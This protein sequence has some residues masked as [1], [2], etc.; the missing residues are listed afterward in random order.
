MI[1]IEAI[2]LI[3][4]DNVVRSYESNTCDR[5]FMR[6][7]RGQSNWGTGSLQSISNRTR[8][9]RNNIHGNRKSFVYLYVTLYKQ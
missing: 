1:M 4:P 2:K 6:P 3:V 5:F 8:V 9:L 7:Q